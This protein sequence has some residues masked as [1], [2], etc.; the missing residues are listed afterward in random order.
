MPLRKAAG[1]LRAELLRHFERFVDGDLRGHVGAPQE[2]EDALAEDVAVDHGHAL[3]LPVLR[4]LG[5]Q[6]VDLPLVDLGAA[7]QPLGEVAYLEIHGMARPELVEVGDGRAF[8]LH[9]Q[10]IEELEGELAGLATLAHQALR[11]EERR[12]G[13]RASRPRFHAAI[14]SAAWAAS[15]PRWPPRRPPAP[16]PAPR[17]AR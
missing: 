2:L 17:S 16:T 4:V 9:V 5:D 14:S 15:S 1:L 11:R 7:H 8:I 6:L 13:P 3:D 10:L 12:A